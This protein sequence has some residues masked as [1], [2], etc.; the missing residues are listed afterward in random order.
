ML[1]EHEVHVWIC[2]SFMK[3]LSN[4]I[5]SAELFITFISDLFLFL[6][7]VKQNQICIFP[8]VKDLAT[9]LDSGKTQPY[10]PHT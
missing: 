7:I 2:I 5:R 6:E 4:C 3:K 9:K 8:K 10:L 1:I